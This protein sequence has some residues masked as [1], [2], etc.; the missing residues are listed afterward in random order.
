QGRGSSPYYID[1]A[2]AQRRAER[3]AAKQLQKLLLYGV[4]PVACPDCGWIQAEMVAEMRKRR[5]RWALPTAISLGI[6]ASLV[7]FIF[8]LNARHDG[9]RDL[10]EGDRVVLIVMIAA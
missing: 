8:W 7:A 4:D 6:V 3:G 1:N 10:D 9:K 2:G 5:H